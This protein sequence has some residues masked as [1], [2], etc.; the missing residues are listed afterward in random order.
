MFRNL[1]K[2]KAM[3]TLIVLFC[4]IFFTACTKPEIEDYK[5]VPPPPPI[6]TVGANP[7]GG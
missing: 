5:N 2:I 7:I 4:I 6:D 1:N 3:K